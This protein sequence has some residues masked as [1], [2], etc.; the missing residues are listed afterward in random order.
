MVVT[1]NFKPGRGARAVYDDDFPFAQAG[2]APPTRASHVEPIQSG[3]NAGRWYA[4]MSPLG[5]GFEFCLWPPCERRDA[6]LEAERRFICER[7]L[8]DGGKET[9][10]PPG[11]A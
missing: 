1:I 7:W 11:E 5:R 3:P 6:A 2:F 9:A 4:D 10:C 8:L